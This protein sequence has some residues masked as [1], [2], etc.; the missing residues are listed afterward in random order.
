M[1]EIVKIPDCVKPNFICTINN[2]EYSYPAGAEMEVPDEVA[3]VIENHMNHRADLMSGQSSGVN[4]AIGT[5]K[6]GDDPDLSQVPTETTVF[7]LFDD[8]L[9]NRC[10]RVLRGIAGSSSWGIY[11]LKLSAGT[12]N[13]EV[14]V[15]NPGGKYGIAHGWKDEAYKTITILAITDEP[16]SREFVAWLKANAT[17]IS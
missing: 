14:Y 5:W 7:V 11:T 8:A 16:H 9:G 15:N 3:C 10:T 17:K 6:F 13:T 4:E 1:S 2:M 12:T